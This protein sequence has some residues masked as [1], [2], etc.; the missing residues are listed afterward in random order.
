[1]KKMNR[2]INYLIVI[3][4]ICLFNT[5]TL[6]A[7]EPQDMGKLTVKLLKSVDGRDEAFYKQYV[8]SVED[9]YKKLM[10]DSYGSMSPEKLAEA[11]EKWKKEF[12]TRLDELSSDA[13]K[14]GVDWKKI[15][16]VSFSYKKDMAGME[17]IYKGDLVFSY[18]KKH[19]SLDVGY[20]IID[21]AL[22]LGNLED[23]K[24]EE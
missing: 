23:L 21:D 11:D 1:M 5:L 14:L 15:K 22:K 24:V 3:A 10:K 12:N 4:F 18:K 17:G 13:E 7:D 6:K 16:S 9:I 8:A 2:K 20:M 19:Y